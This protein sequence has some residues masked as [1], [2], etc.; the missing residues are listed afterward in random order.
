MDDFDSPLDLDG[1]GDDTVEMCLF[2][3]NDGKKK[4]AHQPTGNSDCCVLLLML[5]GAAST[6]VWG[7]TRLLS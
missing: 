4:G 6:M 2:F 7:V 3:D 1:D 5:G